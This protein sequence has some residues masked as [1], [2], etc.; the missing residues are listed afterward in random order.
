MGIHAMQFLD[1]K[2]SNDYVRILTCPKHPVF[3]VNVTVQEKVSF[4]KKTRYHSRIPYYCRFDT[5]LPSFPYQS[6]SVHALP[7][8]GMDKAIFP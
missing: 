6:N 5:S 3:R 8:S 7:G 2:D 4:I 1:C